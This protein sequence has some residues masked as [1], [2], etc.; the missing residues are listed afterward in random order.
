MRITRSDVVA[1][2]MVNRFYTD[3]Q[4]PRS[5][6]S[7][8]DPATFNIERHIDVHLF[9][10]YRTKGYPKPHVREKAQIRARK[11]WNKLWN[12]PDTLK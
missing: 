12:L 3:M 7:K 5:K 6:G 1:D 10:Y 8:F 11:L 4:D 2:E 9:L